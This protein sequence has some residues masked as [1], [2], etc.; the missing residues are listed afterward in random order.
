[1]ARSIKRR[2]G[3]EGE[4]MLVIPDALLKNTTEKNT[5]LAQLYITHLGYFPKADGHYRERRRGCPDNIFFYCIQGKGHYIVGDQQ[6]EAGPNE[7]F[8]IPA[9]SDYIRYWAD[10]H[11][12]WSIYWVHFSGNDMDAFNRSMNITAGDGPLPIPFNAKGI[13][14]WNEMYQGLEMGYSTENICN[15]NFCLYHFLASFLFHDKHLTAQPTTKKDIVNDTVL[16][17][18]EQLHQMLTVEK[19]AA[20]HR[21]SV[22]HFSSVFRKGTGMAPIEYFIHMKMQRACQLL[23]GTTRK[24]K[25]VAKDLGYDDPYYFS[26]IFK[27]YIGIAPEV[28]RMNGGA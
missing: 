21:L 20:L 1:M 4:Q 5:V 23:F 15:A 3:F 10:A 9:T 8:I 14:L 13:Q 18:R 26:R 27:K 28:F 24:I 25:E 22:P 16:Y 7:Y 19:L 6:F 17:M 11:D 2:D 12:P